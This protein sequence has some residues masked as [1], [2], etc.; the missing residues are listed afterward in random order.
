[1]T[2][3]YSLG[4]STNW[5]SE[6]AMKSGAC[7]FLI[8]DNRGDLEK[9]AL[10]AVH[11]LD[12]RDTSAFIACGQHPGELIG[13]SD[14]VR[15]QS[16]PLFYLPFDKD[17][18]I[19]LPLDLKRARICENTFIIV[20]FSE[21][22]L[23]EQMS[24]PQLELWFKSIQQWLA[25]QHVTLLF[26]QYHDK[27]E[28]FLER[29][30]AH[31]FCIGGASR[32]HRKMGALQWQISWWLTPVHRLRNHTYDIDISQQQWELICPLNTSFQIE[33]QNDSLR[34]FMHHHAMGNSLAVDSQ[35]LVFTDIEDIKG[36]VRKMQQSTVILAFE[37]I[38][39][40]EQLARNIHWMRTRCDKS[41]KIVVRELVSFSRFSDIHLLLACGANL[42]VPHELSDAKFMVQLRSVWGQVYTRY[43]APDIDYLLKAVKPIPYK[44]SLSWSVFVELVVQ[45]MDNQ[46]LVS[47][48]KG[49]LIVMRPKARIRPQ[50]II[51]ICQIERQGDII[52]QIRGH[53]FLFLS[54]CAVGDTD[55][56]IEHLFNMPIHDF[57]QKWEIL[58]HDEH[59]KRQ[60]LPYDADKQSPSNP[61]PMFIDIVTESN[62]TSS[63]DGIQ[64]HTP[65]P[66]DLLDCK[67]AG[68]L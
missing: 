28:Q 59:I 9:V 10:Q 18:L 56:A 40:L 21:A 65:T 67:E 34:V 64:V 51:A 17:A 11:A 66:V 61:L 60:L 5:Q 68:D 4:E 42:V 48:E 50:Q 41:L 44:G 53:V 1:M 38:D 52:S 29:L 19:N 6:S 47:D 63:D 62:E 36:R 2:K 24:T 39:S 43:V 22:G 58:H 31:Y 54:S 45:R 30:A 57:S 32:L 27:A 7:Y 23:W 15:I 49:V 3:H 55:V 14:D 26:L 20:Y 12:D 13:A 8:T 33:E 16:M 37:S 25:K 35:W 46:V